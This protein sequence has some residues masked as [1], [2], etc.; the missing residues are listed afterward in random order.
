MASTRRTV[1]VDA[2]RET[3]GVAACDPQGRAYAVL[4]VHQHVPV[5]P[6]AWDHD[7]AERLAFMDRFGIQEACVLPPAVR[8]PGESVEVLNERVAAYREREPTRFPVALGTADLM[9]AE[10]TRRGQVRQLRELGLS[11]VIWHHMFDGQF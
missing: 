5:E 1:G 8:P 4:D 3:G 9:A 11:G 10:A 6:D 7:L 2:V